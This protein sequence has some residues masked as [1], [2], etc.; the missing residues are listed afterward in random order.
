MISKLLDSVHLLASKCLFSCYLLLSIFLPWLNVL[1]T[2]QS[3]TSLISVPSPST[4]CPSC[5]RKARTGSSRCALY[6]VQ[7][8]K[9]NHLLFSHFCLLFVSKENKG[10]YLLVCTSNVLLFIQSF[11]KYLLSA[12]Y[13][14]NGLCVLGK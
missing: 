12:C 9:I 4:L 2:F 14:S 10:N 8:N 3:I 13:I 7:L 11:N 5:I 1:C 6:Q